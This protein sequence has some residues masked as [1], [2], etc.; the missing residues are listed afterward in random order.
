M[1]FSP[2]WW[3][4]MIPWVHFFAGWYFKAGSSVK[5]GWR[6]VKMETLPF[7]L[8]HHFWLFENNNRYKER[9]PWGLRVMCI[10]VLQPVGAKRLSHGLHSVCFS[11]C[12][13]G[14]LRGLLSNRGS[15]RK[16]LNPYRQRF[17]NL[18]RASEAARS[19]LPLLCS[20]L[21][22]HPKCRADNI[23]ASIDFHTDFS[24]NGWNVW[25]QTQSDKGPTPHFTSGKLNRE[26]EKESD[27]VHLLVQT[28]D[29]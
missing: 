6:G 19:A 5:T 8:S 25:D 16:W 14:E 21:S 18:S 3:C 17:N 13:W 20:L 29:I 2:D 22:C 11:R 27:A 10:E 26:R 12:S 4:P 23:K 28:L 9:A 1:L 24:V 7:V 15:L